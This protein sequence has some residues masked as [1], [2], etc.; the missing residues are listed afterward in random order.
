MQ[1]ISLRPYQREK[2]SYSVDKIKERGNS[3]L[4][5]PT[6]A[7]KTIMLSATIDECIKY[8]NHKMHILVLVHRNTINN[9]NIEKFQKVS[10]RRVSLFT[11]ECK[12]FSGQVI[13]AMVQT[14]KNEYKKFPRFDMIVIDECHHALADSYM[15]IIKDQQEKNEKESKKLLLFGVTATPNRGDGESLIGLFDNYSQINIKQLIEMGY[16][17]RPKM[18]D[19][20]PI[21]EI[22]KK[23]KTIEETGLLSKIDFRDFSKEIFEKWQQSKEKFN[24]KKTIIFCNSHNNINILADY[25]KSK[26]VNVS[27]VKDFSSEEE[28]QKELNRFESGDCDVIINVDIL[29]EGY[30]YP[31]IDCI[32]LARNMTVKSLYIQMIGRGLRPLDNTK[33]KAIKKECIVIDF[34]G[35]VQKHGRLDEDVI[36]RE[37]FECEADKHLTIND[38]LKN[39]L[40]IF[41]S[42]IPEEEKERENIIIKGN[43][44]MIHEFY[45]NSFADW[46]SFEDS[47]HGLIYCTCGKK[48][49]VIIS[50]NKAFATID[51]IHWEKIA[52]IPINND[53]NLKF[54]LEAGDEFMKENDPEYQ[55]TVRN[56]PILDMQIEILK[57]RYSLQNCDFYRANTMICW[58]LFRDNNLKDFINN[59]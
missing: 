23:S 40:S 3:L 46:E 4:I 51:K 45:K 2:V 31:P 6:S 15:T 1:G 32:V 9:Q 18:L 25:F 11:A 16:L 17:I 8:I 34:G 48:A 57:A 36:L 10:H 59:N 49:N 55:K 21:V 30:D 13:F 42:E 37:N 39:N 19:F 35:N 33:T 56:K 52:S 38:I 50:D 22:E 44:E 43:V 54:L 26:G 28:R 53:N 29:T 12:D 7:G 58:D 41:N 27:V 14:A 24:F 20:S 47:D 5:A